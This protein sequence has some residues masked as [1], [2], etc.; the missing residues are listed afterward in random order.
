MA[1][2]EKRI[3][4]DAKT[5]SYRAKIRSKGING[6]L[7]RSFPRKKDAEDWARQV[8]ADIRRGLYN[9]NAMAERHSLSDAIDLYLPRLKKTSPSRYPDVKAKLVNP[10]Y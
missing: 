8:E 6:S 2:I 4:K 1:T 9:D 3:S 7:S 5:V 10:H